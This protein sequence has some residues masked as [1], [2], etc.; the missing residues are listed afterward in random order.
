MGLSLI[1]MKTFRKNNENLNFQFFI[2]WNLNVLFNL[3][4]KV[5]KK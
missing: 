1:K 3:K 5:K 2:N 4:T